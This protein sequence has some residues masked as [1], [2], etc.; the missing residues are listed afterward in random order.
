MRLRSR[1]NHV[2]HG[3]VVRSDGTPLDRSELGDPFETQ[4]AYS[5]GRAEQPSKMLPRFYFAGFFGA[6]KFRSIHYYRAE[7]SRLA[8]PHKRSEE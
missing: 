5:R 3:R 8:A 6:Y 4:L 7:A 1:G 2:N